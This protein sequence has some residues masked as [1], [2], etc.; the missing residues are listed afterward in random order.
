M[1]KRMLTAALSTSALLAGA[2]AAPAQASA[3]RAD[4][5]R[6]DLIRTGVLLASTASTTVALDPRTGRV[7]RQIAAGTD[8]TVSR[9]GRVAFAR[10]IDACFPD[11]APD[12]GGCTGAAD[13]LTAR[14]DGSGERAVVHNPE[15][16][17]S[18]SAPDFAPDGRQI[19]F[20]WGVR[21]ER[22]LAVVDADGT[23]F[24]GLVG[25]ASDG[26]FSPDGS[27]V[28]YQLGGDIHVVDVATGETR[29]ITA[30]EG[31][32]QPYAPD[33]SPDGRHIVY[34]GEHEFF[35][36]PAAGGAS[37]GS[38]QWGPQVQR[39]TAPVFSPD[40]RRVAFAATDE[41]APDGTSTTRIYQ[42][43]RDGSGLTAVAEG[44]YRL[45]DWIG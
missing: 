36:V 43:N 15:P 12:G 22:G 1:D 37:V 2:F 38:G 28:A 45:T 32:A 16:S 4:L 27:R 30:G 10:D 34:A 29:T 40:G 14:P 3:P 24:R 18:V 26:T 11:P 5:I 44:N 7:L 20:H 35:V 8:G 39:M 42:A 33:W 23:G 41:S 17:G 9:Q 21:G 6:T 19:V 31:L 13:L 25:S